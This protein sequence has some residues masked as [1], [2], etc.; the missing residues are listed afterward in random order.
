MADLELEE[1][2]V[3]ALFKHMPTSP[4]TH[5]WTPTLDLAPLFFRLTLD[6]ATEFLFGESV[7]SQLAALSGNLGANHQADTRAKLDW[8]RFAASFDGAT[9][10]LGRRARLGQRYWLHSPPAFF[11]NC[12]EVH[13]FA[14]HFVHLALAGAPS[15]SEK[16]ERQGRYVFLQ[17]LVTET[18]DPVELRSQLL[19][20]LLAG[21]DTTAG[22]LGYTFQVLARHPAEYAKL[23]KVLLDQFGTYV[24]PRDITFANLKSCAALQHVMNEILR[25]YPSL[26]ANGRRAVRDTTIP[27]GGGPDGSAPV[28]IKKGQDVTYQVHVMHRRKDLWGEDANNFRPDRWISRKAGWE[29]LPFN[30]GPRVCLG[31]QSCPPISSEDS[32][33]PWFPRTV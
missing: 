32:W 4:A 33:F 19:N 21:R 17:E 22:F 27:R 10:S 16:G 26:P 18:R 24:R 15:R 30:G 5:G 7:N 11:D 13:R 20:I 6:S 14:D 31:K 9:M 3:Q 25:L 1:S 12:K 29:Y 8:T 28:Y 23:R 2:H